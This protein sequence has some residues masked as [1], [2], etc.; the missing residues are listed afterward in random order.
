MLNIPHNEADLVA[1]DYEALELQFHALLF[2]DL[3]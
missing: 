2:M 3:R 1:Q